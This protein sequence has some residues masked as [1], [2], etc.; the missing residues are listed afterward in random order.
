MSDDEILEAYHAVAGKEGILTTVSTLT[1][2]V[3]ENPDQA[4]ALCKAV[5]G[6]GLTLD[7]SH[8]LTGSNQGGNY[9]HVFP[10]VR[11]THLR[12]TGRGP[13]GRSSA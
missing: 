13:P 12:D 6:L 10:F 2:T 9:D 5:P 8:F 7:P 4:V 1:G 3:T 11:H